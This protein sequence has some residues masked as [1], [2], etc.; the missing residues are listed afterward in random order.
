M[1][2][3]KRGSDWVIFTDAVLNH[4]ENYTVPQYGDYPD[5]NVAMWTSSDC[6]KQVE[7]YLKRLNTNQRPGERKRDLLKIAHYTQ[8][9][10]DKLDT[11][12]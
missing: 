4:I 1:N 5:D 12:N 11:E 2:L 8:L 7:R 9:A 10:H 3:S 6:M